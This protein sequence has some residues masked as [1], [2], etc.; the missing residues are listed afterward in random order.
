MRTVTMP[1]A[2][3]MT[4]YQGLPASR[5]NAHTK[6]KRRKTPS[7]DPPAS[8]HLV[9]CHR[10]PFMVFLPR[11]RSLCDPN[12][13]AKHPLRD[14]RTC[15]RR[16][17]MWSCFTQN[18]GPERDATSSTQMPGSPDPLDGFL[19][20]HGLLHGRLGYLS[21]PGSD[22]RTHLCP[23]FCC[24]GHPQGTQNV[25]LSNPHMETESLCRRVWSFRTVD[26]EKRQSHHPHHPLEST[27]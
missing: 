12:S 15:S 11:S 10:F 20:R 23:L 26:F 4:Q 22:R 27:I 17:R 19:G 5:K 6:G 18:V 24:S 3:L 1:C 14:P 7:A 21:H 8:L 25:P 13:V 9:P 16:T 2:D